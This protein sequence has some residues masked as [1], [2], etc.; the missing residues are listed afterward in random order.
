MEKVKMFMSAVVVLALLSFFYTPMV[1]AQVRQKKA[2]E[3]DFA[4]LLKQSDADYN[5]KRYGACITNLRQAISLATGMH[6]WIILEA[7]PPAP[8][9]YEKVPVQK[10]ELDN[11]MAGAMAG[12]IGVSVEQTY[13]QV[14]GNGDIRINVTAHSPLVP[15]FEMAFKMAAMDPNIEVVTYNRFKALFKKEQGGKLFVLQIPIGGKHH[16]EVKVRGM[17][18]DTFFKVFNQEFVD[19]IAKALS[20]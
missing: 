10:Q 20:S 15:M 11:P 1:Q 8:S 17:D 4:G 14:Q 13:R 9:G 3:R 6:R 2:T 16:L 5:A 19:R 18:E 7:M 12:S